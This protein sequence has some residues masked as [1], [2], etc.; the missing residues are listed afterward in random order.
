VLGQDDDG[1]VEDLAASGRLR[2]GQRTSWV[3]DDTTAAL[4]GP[5]GAA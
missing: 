1:G 4:A 3:S 5:G 2:C